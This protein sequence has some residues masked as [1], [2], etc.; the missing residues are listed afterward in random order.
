LLTHE[1]ACLFSMVT[2]ILY[3]RIVL[4]VMFR[5]GQVTWSRMQGGVCAYLLIGLAWASAYEFAEL[6]H[7]HSFHF[8]SAPEDMSQLSSKLVYFSF[9]TLT[10]VG[11]G[12]ITPLYPA[13]RSLAIAEAIMGQLLPAILIATLV[14]MAL[15]SHSKS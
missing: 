13:A 8:V 1:L 5:G 3:V 7:P 14:T 10:T 6:V 4:H 9:A 12:D 15:Q 11:F 2:A